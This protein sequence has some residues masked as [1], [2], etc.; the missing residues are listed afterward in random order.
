VRIE[1]QVNGEPH[2]ATVEPRT[3]LIDWL[4]DDLQLT[5][6]KVGCDDG[7]CGACT[8]FVDSE[9]ASPCLLL[10][11]QADG[12]EIETIEGLCE[13]PAAVAAQQALMEHHAVQCGYC[14]PGIVT[15]L[16]AARRAG[17]AA[18]EER[19]RLHLDANLCR[20]TGYTGMVRAAME[21]LA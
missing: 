7:S 16:V 9:L 21:Y 20:C 6:P 5:G 17:L 12:A 13:D 14:A 15:T 10:A 18:D 19:L 2:A 11:V 3:L 8:V 4:R 1:V